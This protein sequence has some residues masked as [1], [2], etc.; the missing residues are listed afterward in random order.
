MVDRPRLLDRGVC[1]SCAMWEASEEFKEPSEAD[2]P[3]LV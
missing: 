3:T 2:Q 1:E